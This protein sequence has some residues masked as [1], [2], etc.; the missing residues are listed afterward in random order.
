MWQVERYSLYLQQFGYDLESALISLERFTAS[1]QQHLNADQHKGERESVPDGSRFRRPAHGLAGP[2]IKR[3]T[4][5][6]APYEGQLAFLARVSANY[7]FLLAI[8]FVV[9]VVVSLMDS[10]LHTKMRETCE[11]QHYACTQLPSL[12]TCDENDANI[13]LTISANAS[14]YLAETQARRA[15]PTCAARGPPPTAHSAQ[16]FFAA[17]RL[18]PAPL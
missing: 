7:G 1:D 3:W 10:S 11:L 16:A 17:A 2:R 4:S 9:S 6:F 13:T 12:Y 5:G 15:A 8:Y 14:A 18:L